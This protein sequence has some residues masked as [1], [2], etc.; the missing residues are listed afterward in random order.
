MKVLVVALCAAA[1]ALAPAAVA[2]KKGQKKG[3]KHVRPKVERL[4]CRL[5]TEDQHARIAVEL[6]NGKVNRFAYYSKW[7]PRTCSME[8]ERGDAYSSW[9]ETGNTIVVT[10]IE[11]K[12]AFL[13]DHERNRY[14]FI[15]REIDRMRYCGMEGK[16]SGSL[17]IFRGKPQCL[18]EGVME[19]GED[20]IEI[21]KT[22]TQATTPK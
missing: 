19:K 14:H 18:L 21:D 12:G 3:P 4:A 10:L 5:G 9:A 2:Q 6:V 20:M 22:S 7:K 13:I 17:T 15:F 8:V 16:V 11:D 1:L